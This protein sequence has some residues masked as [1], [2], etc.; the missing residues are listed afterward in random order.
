MENIIYILVLVVSGIQGD[1][2]VTNSLAIEGYTDEQ[3]CISDLTSLVRSLD[4]PELS[5]EYAECEAMPAEV[6]LD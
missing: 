6:R 3:Q 2:T 4:Y 1:L 5:I